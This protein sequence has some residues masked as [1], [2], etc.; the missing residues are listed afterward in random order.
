MAQPAPQL[1]NPCL[2][3]EG[4]QIPAKIWE[5]LR[6][7]HYFRDAVQRLSK[8]DTKERSDWAKTRKYHGSAWEKSCRLVKRVEAQ[9]GFAGVALKWLVP[10][11]CFQIRRV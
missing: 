1:Y 6:R 9:H 11:P 7:N 4:D 10:E 2:L 5:L 3:D 8:L